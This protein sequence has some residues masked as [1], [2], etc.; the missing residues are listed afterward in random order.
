LIVFQPVGAG[1]LAKTDSKSPQHYRQTKK[2][3]NPEVGV[4][5]L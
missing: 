3:A 2:N 4:F 1:L 5:H